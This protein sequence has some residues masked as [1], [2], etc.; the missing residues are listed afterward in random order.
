[1]R[2]MPPHQVIG[3][4]NISGLANVMEDAKTSGLDHLSVLAWNSQE[5]G[6][7]TWEQA[8]KAVPLQN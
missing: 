4:K 2:V 1:M 3:S 5:T 7:M 6:M 8:S